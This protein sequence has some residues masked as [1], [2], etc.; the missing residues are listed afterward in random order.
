MSFGSDRGLAEACG[1]SCSLKA[2]DRSNRRKLLLWWLLRSGIAAMFPC[3]MLPCLLV[4][5]CNDRSRGEK[6]RGSGQNQGL[7]VDPLARGNEFQ[8]GDPLVDISLH[9][10]CR[11]ATPAIY[12]KEEAPSNFSHAL[13]KEMIDMLEQTNREEMGKKAGELGEWGTLILFCL[14]GPGGP[15]SIQVV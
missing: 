10:L 5:R 15:C 8:L 12:E 2:A 13:F 7:T 6:C 11:L 14:R 1:S 9:C 4:F 3:A